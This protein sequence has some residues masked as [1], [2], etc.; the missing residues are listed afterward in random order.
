MTAAKLLEKD[1]IASDINY[2]MFDLKKN[3]CLCWSVK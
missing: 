3:Q 2:K 1:F